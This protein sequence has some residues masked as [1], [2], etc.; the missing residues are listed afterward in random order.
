[1]ATIIFLFLLFNI[2]SFS[3]QTIEAAFFCGGV[4]WEIY[5]V[6]G[7][8][9]SVI[10]K[11]SDLPSGGYLAPYYFH[12][13]N[14]VPG[15]LIKFQCYNFNPSPGL[16]GELTRS[17]G[18]GCFLLNDNCYCYDFDSDLPK[19]NDDFKDLTVHLI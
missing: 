4:L 1:M 10:A 15:D 3:S 11:S 8:R 2:F 13:L 14:A 17:F 18:A 19:D 7:T 12:K 9:E 5:V 6:E 16:F